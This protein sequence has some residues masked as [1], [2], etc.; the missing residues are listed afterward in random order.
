MVLGFGDFATAFIP[1]SMTT[2]YPCFTVCTPD[3]HS[4]AT[5]KQINSTDS[6]TAIQKADND[7]LMNHHPKLESAQKRGDTI[8]RSSNRNFDRLNKNTLSTLKNR[9]ENN[10]FTRNL[11]SLMIKDDQPVKAQTGVSSTLYFEPFA[12]KRIRNIRIQQLDVFGPTLQD[13]TRKAS[14]WIDKTA[15]TVHLKTTEKKLRGQL[16]FNP[17]EFVNPQLM[18]ENEKFI[19]DL[20]YIQDVAITLIHSRLEEDFVDVVVI[21]KEKFEYAI[22]GNLNSSRTEW[23]VTDQ[24][25]FGIGHQ[26]SVKTGYNLNETP[27]WEGSFNYEISDLDRKFIRTGVGYTNTYR[28]QA[29]NGFIEKQFIASKKDW[30]GG[31]SLER[32]FS[33]HFLTPYSYTALDTAASYFN[34]DLWYGKQINNRSSN[35]TIGN[36]VIS[37]RYF[38][39]NF[40]HNSSKQLTNSLLRNHD[41]I[42]G[43]IGISKRYLFKNNRVYGYGITEDIPYGRYAEVAAGIDLGPDRSRP[44][45]HFNY[46]KASILNGGAYFKWQIGMGGF[47]SNS[48]LEQGAILLSSNFFSNFIYPIR[49]PYR[50]FVNMELLSGINRFKEEYLVIN[51]RFGIRDYFSLDTKGI[52]RLKINVEAVSFW[53][54]HKSG[55]R[56]AHYFFADA[57]FLSND[58]CNV[59]NDRFYAGFGLG[60]RVH[61]ES[62]VFNVLEVRLSWIPIAPSGIDPYI[63]NAFGQPK[64]RFDD[65]LGGKPHEIA[66]Q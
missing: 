26:F 55:F 11:F 1:E 61:N 52:D 62:L 4:I 43:A 2:F 63:F 40:Y 15:N 41:F 32:V 36:V 65:F 18:A 17:G 44:Y 3:V 31:I 33:D 34:S 47:L 48:R 22:N 28:E 53:N 59:L 38:H 57:A 25:M 46:S 27:K 35:P 8:R 56:F 60:I 20:P 16:L 23:E 5:G 6:L 66:Y 30:A 19:R 9:G 39:Q 7:I 58:L 64:A 45:F 42:L 12:G 49:R 50:L 21:I 51:R 29:A 10:F 24:N 14:V 13:T 37:S 54:W